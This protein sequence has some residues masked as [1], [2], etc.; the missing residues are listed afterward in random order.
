MYFMYVCKLCELKANILFIL[1]HS[2]AYWSF[3][4]MQIKLFAK[5]H[6]AILLS[7]RVFSDE[8]S[9]T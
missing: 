8:A 5:Q 1:W 2:V 7:G 6:S 3:S 9:V 4:V